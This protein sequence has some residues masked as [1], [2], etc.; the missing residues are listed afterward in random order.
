MYKIRKITFHNHPILGNLFLDFCNPEGKSVDTVILAGENGTG[1]STILNA[2]YTLVS[3]VAD[4]EADVEYETNDSI[5]VMTYKYKDLTGGKRYLYA[6]DGTGMNA[7]LGSKDVSNKYPTTGI[8][9]D[10]DINFHSEKL[11]SVT[12]LT[13]DEK[14]ESRRSSNDLPKQ[15]N[16]LLIDI[17]ALDDA[18]VAFAVREHPELAGKDLG[19]EERMPRVTSAF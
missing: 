18:D 10:V 16:Q 4:F 15:I 19:V 13:L 8:Y 7:R 5:F 11:S 3:R 17:Q 6:S 14:S 1:K 12:S 2:I 9:S